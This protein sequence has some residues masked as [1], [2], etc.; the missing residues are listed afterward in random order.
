MNAQEITRALQNCHVTKSSFVGVFSA[1]TVPTSFDRLPAACVVNTDPKDKP[2]EH[3]V[4][5]YQDQADVIE[6]FDSFGMHPSKQRLDLPVLKSKRVVRQSNVLQTMITAVCG[7]YCMF[8]LFHRAA[9][10]SF[11]K[12]ISM[13]SSNTCA[14]DIL[15]KSFVDKTFQL[16]SNLVDFKFMLDL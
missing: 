4:A 10:L 1:D 14:N 7:Q 11:A 16:K 15:V 5:L 12:I 3:W 13:F 6:Y 8:F 2:G 9:G